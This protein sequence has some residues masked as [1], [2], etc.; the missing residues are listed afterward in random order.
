MLL[1]VDEC[2][3]NTNGCAHTCTNTRGSYSC[4][5]DPGYRLASD[6]HS[7]ADIDECAEDTDGCN[8]TCINTVGSYMCSCD[9][10][11]RLASDKQKCNGKP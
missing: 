4:S 3:E 7:C 6:R 10:G 9:S 8:Q 5:C 1:D 11:Y 2:V